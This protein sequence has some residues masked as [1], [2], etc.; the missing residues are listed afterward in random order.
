M[1]IQQRKITSS[2]AVQDGETVALGGLIKDS[3]QRANSGIPYLK[4][5]PILGALA[6]NIAN[7]DT[8]TE[9]LVMLTPRVVRDAQTLRGI[10]SEMRDH[11]AATR[12]LLARPN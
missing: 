6:S 5:I 11:I 10:T 3:D 12:P 2:I 4:D 8:R 9:L 7:S 1:T